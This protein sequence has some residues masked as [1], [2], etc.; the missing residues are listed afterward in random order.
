MK[1]IT[2][3]VLLMALLITM[4]SCDGLNNKVYKVTT[5]E[6]GVKFCE[7]TT[8]ENDEIYFSNFGGSE[9]NPLNMDGKGYIMKIKGRKVEIVIPANGKLNAPKGM[10]IEDDFLYIADVGSVMIYNLKNKMAEPIKIDFPEGNLFVNDIVIE[11][12]IAYISVTNTGKI[13]KLNI[14]NPAT[15]S[16]KEL[17]EY[18]NI[19]GAN[20]LLIENDKMYVASYSPDGVPTDD[21]T[22]YLIPNIYAPE[23]IRLISRSGQYDGLALS[24]K[25]DKLYFTNWINGEVGYV[26]LKTKEVVIMDITN[27]SFAGPADMTYEDGK[28]YIADLP[29]SKIVIINVGK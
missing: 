23:V 7:G 5:I 9:L 13:F 11:E 8:E 6:S 18:V 20:G 1:K 10:A 19:P 25:E 16:N 3:N 29:N 22:I 14:S 21:N 2:T 24:E 26:I 4:T 15:L 28:L 12:D 27:Y 17:T